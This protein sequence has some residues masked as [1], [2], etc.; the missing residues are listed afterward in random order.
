LKVKCAE[1]LQDPLPVHP[2][3]QKQ[4]ELLP[5]SSSLPTKVS[6]AHDKK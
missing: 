3:T 5:V 1:S 4:R 2:K 6:D